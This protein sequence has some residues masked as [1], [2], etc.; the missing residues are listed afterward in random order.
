LAAAFLNKFDPDAVMVVLPSD[1]V[2]GETKKFLNLI[3]RS[4]E[5]ANS[6][7]CLIT[8]GM[9]PHSPE[10]GY[11]YIQLGKSY[12]NG[13]LGEFFYVKKFFEKPN[14]KKAEAFVKNGQ[15]LWNSGMFIWKAKAILDAIRIHLPELHK[16]LQ[17]VQ[18]HLG[19]SGQSKAI[20]KMYERVTKISIDYG[21]MEKAQNVLVGLGNFV[22]DD[23]GSWSSLERHY[24]KDSKGNVVLGNHVHLATEDCIVI[25]RSGIVATLGVKSLMII[26]LPDAVLVMDKDKAQDV[27]G[28][29]EIL[30]AHEKY[31]KYL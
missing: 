27:K 14:L 9:K 30:K 15:Y 21:I 6:E 8:L 12:S 13:K 20:L 10:T 2:I 5:I 25:G 26:H 3:R 29:V 31:R 16:E 22:W 18:K 4:C 19:T 7:E 1:H 24:K 23:V 11:G 28:I 17:I